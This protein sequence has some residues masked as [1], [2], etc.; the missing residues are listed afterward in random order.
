MSFCDV[1][2][3]TDTIGELLK[4]KFR[5]IANDIQYYSYIILQV[6]LDTPMF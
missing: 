2:S 1:F 4:D 5:I 3:R 6:K